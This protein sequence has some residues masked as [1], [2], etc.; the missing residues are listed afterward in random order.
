MDRSTL[1]F[2]KSN[3]WHWRWMQMEKTTTLHRVASGKREDRIYMGMNPGT[4][5]CGRKGQLYMPGVA[6]RMGAPRCKR[7]CKLLGIP[8]GEGAPYNQGINDA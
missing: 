1:P 2:P 6:S 7:C 3:Q 5:V 4:T 8:L